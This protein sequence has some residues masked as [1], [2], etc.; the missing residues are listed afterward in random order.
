M[1][2]AQGTETV[3]GLGIAIAKYNAA[4]ATRLETFK[5]KNSGVTAKVVDTQPLF[6]TAL[7]NPTAYNSPDATCTNGDGKSCLW[8]NEYHPG[9]EINLL[10]AKAVADA[11]KGSFF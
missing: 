6:N 7:D 1:I 10:V 11:Y 4:I 5:S 3:Q 2:I 8:F 9:F